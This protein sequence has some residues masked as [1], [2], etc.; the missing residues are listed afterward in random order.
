MPAALTWDPVLHTSVP[1][2]MPELEMLL[3]LEFPPAVEKAFWH[4]EEVYG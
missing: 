1:L 2:S 3:E 4:A